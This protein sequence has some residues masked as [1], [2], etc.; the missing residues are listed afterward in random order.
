MSQV[1]VDFELHL[2]PTRQ[3]E[4][5]SLV[6]VIV[7]NLGFSARTDVL[8][9]TDT[10]T[11]GQ[12]FFPGIHWC[13]AFVGIK[14]NSSFSCHYVI[15]CYFSLRGSKSRL[16]GMLAIGK[17]FLIKSFY[18][19]K[20]ATFAIIFLSSLNNFKVNLNSTYSFWLDSCSFSRVMPITS[21][22]Q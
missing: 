7:G 10:I 14:S 9:N 1:R 5:K 6:L 3:L 19:S 11:N 15:H 22:M 13:I 4:L 20:K 18:A 17:L 21:K 8:F 12:F 2:N 16:R